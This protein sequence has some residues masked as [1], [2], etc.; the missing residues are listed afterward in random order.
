MFGQSNNSEEVKPFAAL[1]GPTQAF[2]PGTPNKSTLSTS[3]LQSRLGQVALA[4]DKKPPAP[5]EEKRIVTAFG[6]K[7]D[8]DAKPSSLWASSAGGSGAASA[9]F[10]TKPHLNKP[11]F[12]SFS[13]QAAG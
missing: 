2:G 10:N 3:N 9:F 8:P 12:G 6:Q 7:I 13:S 5:S 1:A 4:S 11:L